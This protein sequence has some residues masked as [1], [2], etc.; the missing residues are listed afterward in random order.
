MNDSNYFLIRYSDIPILHSSNST[1]FNIEG[2]PIPE[3]L[4]L[5]MKNPPDQC[6]LVP[7]S[8]DVLT[9]DQ[10]WNTKKH[11]I[12]LKDVTQQ[13]QSKNIRVSVFLDADPTMIEPLVDIGA[14]RIELYTG[15]YAKNK[16]NKEELNKHIITAELA[17]Q[18]GLKVNAGHDLNLK[19]LKKYKQNMPYL[20]EVS[21]GHALIADALY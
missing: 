2:N 12:F 1:E 7:D 19:N 9:S 15:D 4:D 11:S 10:G 16:E 14:D 8:P 21:I 18:A 6:T 3:F 5:V 13:L 20:V 17:H